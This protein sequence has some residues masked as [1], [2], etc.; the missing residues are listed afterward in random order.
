M[1]SPSLVI[2][3]GN[4]SA[5][6]STVTRDL[7]AQLGY[8]VFLE[9]ATTNPF[10]ADFYRDPKRFA[11]RMQVYL[12]R[13]R[14]HT[15]VAAVQHMLATG[16]GAVLD[17]SIF[18][19]WVFAEKNRLDG[20]IDTEGFFYY[21]QLRDRMLADLPFP[22]V[23][24]YLDVTPETCYQRI[25]GLRMRQ[26]EVDSGIPLEYLAGL[27]RCYEQFLG[28]M[29]QRGSHVLRLDWSAFGTASVV[30]RALAALAPPVAWNASALAAI[31][32]NAAEMAARVRAPM[33]GAFSDQLD[34]ADEALARVDLDTSNNDEILG[35]SAPA[36]PVDKSE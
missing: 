8:R 30:Q 23:T 19:D 29:S 3:E 13:R 7:A 18:S 6:K 2:I 31:V 32:D 36:S 33:G 34:E 5:G 20:N 26:A 35:M 11:L 24:V 27:H 12:L 4:I 14:F 17:R 22:H 15:Y 25:H 16:Q 1:S 28:H 10:L 9:P 21:S